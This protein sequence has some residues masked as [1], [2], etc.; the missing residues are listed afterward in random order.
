MSARDMTAG[1]PSGHLIRYAWPLMLGQWLHLSYNAVDAIIAGRFIGRD[2]L[3]AEGIAAPVMNLVILAVNGLCM[4]AGVLMSEFFG[5]KDRENLRRTL[6]TTLIVGVIA[7]CLVAGAGIWLTPFILTGLSVPG[8]IS[9]ITG[10]Y[11]RVTFL[12]APFTFIY[13]ALSAGL[14]SMGDAKTPLKFLAFS[15]ILNAALDLV[16]LGLLGFGVVCSAA[17]TVFA[18]AVSAGLAV[19]YTVRRVPELCPEKGGWRID[20]SLLRRVIRYGG[21]TA[22]QSAIQPICKVLIQGQV[23]ML[24]VDGI[25]A[26]NAVTRMDDYACVTAQQISAGITTYMGQNRGA[27]KKHRLLPGFLAGIRLEVCWWFVICPVTLLLRGPIVSLFV[28]GEGT[29]EVIRIGSAYLT[30]M[31]PLYILPGLTN[32]VQGFFRGMGKMYTTMAA[33]FIQASLRTVCVYLLVPRIGLPG[34]A[35]SCGIGWTMMLVF[36]VPYCIYTCRRCG[37]TLSKGEPKKADDTNETY[38]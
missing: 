33:T 32:G 1:A 19:W 29:A 12:G 2:A 25:A 22:L 9:D 18:E 17:T 23:N 6:T 16:F 36:E 34:V 10:A 15:S 28:D 13:S 38:P 4:G 8:D 3:A 21:P 31:A 24:G 5:A 7:C 14:K 20:R 11:L 35:L 30:A 27:G 26:F 37:L